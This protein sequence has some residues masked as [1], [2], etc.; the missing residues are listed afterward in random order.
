MRGLSPARHRGKPGSQ[1]LVGGKCRDTVI[2]E[3]QPEDLPGVALQRC[4]SSIEKKPA[5]NA[6]VPI[7]AIEKPIAH[8]ILLMLGRKFRKSTVQQAE[9]HAGAIGRT[10]YLVRHAQATPSSGRATARGR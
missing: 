5:R 2:I 7:T 4:Q 8:W 9:Q 6:I 3:Q 1:L 10:T